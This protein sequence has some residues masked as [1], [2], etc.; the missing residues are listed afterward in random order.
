M[1]EFKNKDGRKKFITTNVMNHLFMEKQARDISFVPLERLVWVDV[2]G[3]PLHAWSK[4]ALRKI[5]A[6]WNTLS[7]LDD[8][9]GD[10]VYRNCICILTSFQ[11]IILEV[12]KIQVDGTFFLI[13]IKE[14]SGWTPFLHP[15]CQRQLL[16]I[17]R[18]MVLLKKRMMFIPCMIK[19]ERSEDPFGIYETLENMQKDEKRNFDSKIQR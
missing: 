18:P 1:F 10:G 11:E 19:E 2:E 9:L 16:K 12:I 4:D 14:A 8:D 15:N 7:H 5:I 6:K 3:L 13:R 17:V